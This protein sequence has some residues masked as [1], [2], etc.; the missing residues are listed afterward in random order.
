MRKPL[1]YNATCTHREEIAEGLAIFRVRADAPSAETFVPGQYTVLGMNHPDKG[2]VSRAYSIASPPQTLPDY[3]EFYVRYVREPESDNPLTH[4]LFTLQPGDRLY[5]GPKIVGHF[6]VDHEIGADDPRLRVCIAAGTGLAPFYSMVL[7]AR[8]RGADVSQFLVVHGVGYGSDLG[9]REALE[10]AM[11]ADPAR[12]RFFP[13]VS[14]NIDDA[15]RYN[16]LTG[17][18]ESHFQPERI[19]TLERAA[20]LPEGFITPDNAAVFIC[21]LQG[22][23]AQSLLNLFD[24]GFLPKDI[25]MR[26]ALGIPEEAPA[27]IFFEQYDS[28]PIL[29]LEDE[30]LVNDCRETLTKA[31]VALGDP[32]D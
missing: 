2:S 12:R 7:D 25:K 19:T 28:S 4:L 6:T 10:K 23:I 9:Y 5:I 22:T 8:N 31:G 15:P 26:R 16:A 17:R 32:T 30:K 1:E 20:G 13:T 3:F 24:R 14:R 11:N 29:D 21:G 27:S 18:A